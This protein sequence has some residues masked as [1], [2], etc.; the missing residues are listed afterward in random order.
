VKSS[1]YTCQTDDGAGWPW[2][3][4]ELCTLGA[5][6][7]GTFTITAEPTATSTY[8]GTP[9]FNAYGIQIRWQLDN[10]PTKT[11]H[12]STITSQPTTPSEP[13]TSSPLSSPASLGGLSTGAKVG[14]GVGVGLGALVVIVGVLSIVF[15]RRR[16]SFGNSNTQS[17]RAC[18]QQVLTNPNL[19]LQGELEGSRDPSHPYELDS[20]GLPAELGSGSPYHP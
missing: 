4:T 7:T 3:S 13:G 17:S 11:I 16:K 5:T 19:Y 6:T 12:T 18:S 1:A 14:V 20:K 15:I 10:A 8:I 2:Y 9:K